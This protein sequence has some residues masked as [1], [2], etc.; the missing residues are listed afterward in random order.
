MR[1]IL[2]QATLVLLLTLPARAQAAEPAAY[3]PTRDN[4][5]RRLS[6]DRPGKKHWVASWVAV[7]AVNFLDVHSSRGRLEANPLLR[8][9]NGR[10]STGKAVLLKA[11]VSGGLFAGQWAWMRT[12]P[13]RNY[14]PKLAVVN[15]IAA[16]GLGAVVVH[17]YRLPELRPR[18]PA[19]L[20]PT[21]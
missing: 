9:R 20:A 11:A 5:A 10:F 18:V 19:H 8:G 4:R 7:A 2:Q 6:L 17:N 21:P 1:R 13:E 3:A 16:G 14:Y 12:H 15:V